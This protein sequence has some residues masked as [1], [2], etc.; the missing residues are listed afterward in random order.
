MPLTKLHEL[1]QN[2][3]LPNY[4]EELL[5]HHKEIIASVKE[6]GKVKTAEL[7]KMTAPKFSIV[8]KMILAYSMIER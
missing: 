7:L 6:I 4:Y 1:I 2:D 8:Y 5:R 3:H